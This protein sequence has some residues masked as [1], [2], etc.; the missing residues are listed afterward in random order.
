MENIVQ[1]VE[2]LITDASESTRKKLMIQLRDLSY[3]L[4][5]DEDT[6][7]RVGYLVSS[8]T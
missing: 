7:R 4:E 8:L 2:Q 3:S 6:V 5:D 1:Q